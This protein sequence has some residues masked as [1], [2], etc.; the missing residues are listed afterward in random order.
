MFANLPISNLVLVLISL[1]SYH[2]TYPKETLQFLQL[3]NFLFRSMLKT[4]SYLPPLIT[5]TRKFFHGSAAV[6][7]SQ[8]SNNNH[9]AENTKGEPGGEKMPSKIQLDEN[10]WFL[11]TCIQKSDMKTVRVY[12][13]GFSFVYSC[14]CITV[15]FYS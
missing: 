9:L 3:Y 13:C 15:S 5:P 7:Q 12:S 1:R 4:L 10:L 8:P 14:S 2:H 6:N 11:Y